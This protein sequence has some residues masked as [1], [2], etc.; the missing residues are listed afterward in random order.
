MQRKYQYICKT[1]C[2]IP[3][4][5]LCAREYKVVMGKSPQKNNTIVPTRTILHQC[6]NVITVTEVEKYQKVFSIDPRTKHYKKTSYI[7][8]RL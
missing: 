6:F 7:L 3:I 2:Q 1:S 4:N 8:N 5:E